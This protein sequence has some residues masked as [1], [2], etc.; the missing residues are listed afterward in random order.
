MVL[1][2]LVLVGCGSEP[3]DVPSEAPPPAPAACSEGTTVV[4]DTCGPLPELMACAKALPD[5]ATGQDGWCKGQ[6]RDIRWT[7][8]VGQ[9]GACRT[10]S[11]VAQILTPTAGASTVACEQ[12]STLRWTP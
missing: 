1:V 5:G 12:R 3:L 8:T 10:A 7:L 6:G 9:D 11:V 4:S 2:A